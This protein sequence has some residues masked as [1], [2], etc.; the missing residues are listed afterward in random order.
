MDL[1]KNEIRTPLQ[2]FE[3]VEPVQKAKW[4][5]PELSIID[6]IIVTSVAI[7]IAL[8]AFTVP[9]LIANA[10]DISTKNNETQLIP[11]STS[12]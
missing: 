1:N 8:M 12:E 3:T 4:K 10:T 6:V 9:S 5:M 11:N 7:L 2:A